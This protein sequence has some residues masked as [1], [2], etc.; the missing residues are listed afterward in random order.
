VP[1]VFRQIMTGVENCD[2]RMAI[3]E[4]ASAAPRSQSILTK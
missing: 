1:V 4:P 3:G 2:W